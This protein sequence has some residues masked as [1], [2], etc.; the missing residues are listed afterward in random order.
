MYTRTPVRGAVPFKHFLAPGRPALEFSIPQTTHVQGREQVSRTIESFFFPSPLALVLSLTFLGDIG[1]IV[2]PFVVIP[3]IF[4]GLSQP[5]T[6][7]LRT[8]REGVDQIYAK[9]IVSLVVYS[10]K[11][12]INIFL[13]RLYTMCHSVCIE[14]R[15][16]AHRVTLT[17]FPA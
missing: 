14:K 5:V 8:W 6:G 16:N 10:C 13:L 1:F 7:G 3:I 15:L 2:F 9:P 11:L 17:S 4:P 12:L